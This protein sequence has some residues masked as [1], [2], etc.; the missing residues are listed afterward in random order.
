MEPLKKKD[1]M[2]NKKVTSSHLDAMLRSK[3]GMLKHKSIIFWETRPFSASG[4]LLSARDRGRS[5]GRDRRSKGCRLE[6]GAGRR[7]VIE[8]P[9]GVG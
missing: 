4:K 5:Q 3:S 9:K 6:T 7:D 8:G 2:K 1:S